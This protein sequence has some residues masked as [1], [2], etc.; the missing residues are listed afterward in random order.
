MNGGS[1]AAWL[2]SSVSGSYSA[3][4][5]AEQKRLSFEVAQKSARAF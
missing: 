2:G 5:L 4:A 3:T 1:N